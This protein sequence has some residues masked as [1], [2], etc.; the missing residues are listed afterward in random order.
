MNP[1]QSI[2]KM[3]TNK[4]SYITNNRKVSS[5]NNMQQADRYYRN[6]SFRGNGIR[7]K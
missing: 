6:G 4:Q 2:Y 3:F 1:I 7:N 5:H